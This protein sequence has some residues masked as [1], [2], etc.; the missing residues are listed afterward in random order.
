MT[1]YNKINGT[2]VSENAHIMDQILRKDWGW[3]GPVMS[4]WFGTYST[5]ESINAGLDIEMPGPSR[6]RGPIALHALRSNKI[7]TTT[8]DERARNVLILVKECAKSGIPEDA[9]EV[10]LDNPETSALLRKLAG[11]SVVLMK[12]ENNVLPLSKDKPVSGISIIAKS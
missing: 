6:W 12:N 3:K 9:P 5:S 11:D 1:A 2:H 8:L 10:K 4:D 7:A